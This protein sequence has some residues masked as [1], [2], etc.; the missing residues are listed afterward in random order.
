ML[1]HIIPSKTRRKILSLFFEHVGDTFHL[2]KVQREVG[3]EIN[4]VKREL[5]ILEKEGILK[6]ERRINKVIY[7]LD[8]RY[9]LFEEFLRICTKTS[10]FATKLLKNVTRLGSLK[11]I[12]L[13]TKFAKRQKISEGEIYIL[14]VG[15]VVAPEVT[16]LVGE[17]EKKWGREINYTIM[18]EEEFLF[19]KKNNDPFM[20]SFLKQPKIML[21][22]SEEHLM[23]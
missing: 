18:T 19:R 20:W 3:E 2:R 14:F 11:Y 21:L 22:G 16:T 9:F 1:E 8:P 13:S 5:T 10:A 7:S 12:V 4:A 15:T 17:E 6:K 23:K